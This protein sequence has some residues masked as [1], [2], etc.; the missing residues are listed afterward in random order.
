M[1]NLINELITPSINETGATIPVSTVKRRAAE[2]IGNLYNQGQSDLQARL[3]LQAEVAELTHQLVQ[4]QGPPLE[5]AKAE[6]G[7][8]MNQEY[9]NACQ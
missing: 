4:L 1:Q 9:V 6:Y 3:R 2:A 8:V 5:Y 7:T